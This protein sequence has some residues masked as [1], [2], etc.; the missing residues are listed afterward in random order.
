M[1]SFVWKVQS[2]VNFSGREDPAAPVWRALPRKT[3]QSLELR[4]CCTHTPSLP[5]TTLVLYCGRRN[6]VMTQPSLVAC[7][8]KGMCPANRSLLKVTTPSARSAAELQVQSVMYF[9]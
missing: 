2:E 9:G 3:G 8:T 4:A 7:A 6:S 1:L 5:R